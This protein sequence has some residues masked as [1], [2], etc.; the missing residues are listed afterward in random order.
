MKKFILIVVALMLVVGE[1]WAAD[2]KTVYGK[3]CHFCHEDGILGSPM[4]GN[5]I[6]WKERYEKG[7]ENLYQSAING[8]GHMSERK[9]RRN[10]NEADIKRAVDYLLKESGI[11]E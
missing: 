3:I 7:I 10:F 2:G 6:E 11:T 8:I 1:V 9:G 4:I 5:R